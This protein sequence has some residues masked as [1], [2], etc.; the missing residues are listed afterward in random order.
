MDFHLSP[1]E[2]HRHV[3]K[4][5]EHEAVY[6]LFT[7]PAGDLF[8]MARTLFSPDTVLEILAVRTGERTWVWQRRHACAPL[9]H[10]QPD[11]SGPTLTLRCAEPWARWHLAFHENVQAT[12][13]AAESRPLHLEAEFKATGAP[14]GHRFGPTFIQGEQ[15]GLLHATLTLGEQTWR[16]AWPCI[17]D[18]TWGQ[19]PMTVVKAAQVV[20]I[21][22]RLHAILV[23]TPNGTR[24]LGRA[25]DERGASYPLQAPQLTPTPSG[26]RISDPAAGNVSWEFHRIASPLVWHLGQAGVESV[27]DVVQPGDLLREETGPARFTTPTGETLI[28]FFDQLWSVQI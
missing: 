7:T 9:L 12:A 26:W 5:G 15:S 20:I 17:R 25:L 1:H 24:H 14:A 4:P 18:H 28:G 21:P 8:G 11:A 2:D 23:E 19:R 27:R 22:N 10:P 16:G 6:F 13:D 3:L